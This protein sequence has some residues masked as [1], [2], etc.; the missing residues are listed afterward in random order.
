MATKKKVKS[1][2]K[3]KTPM[4]TRRRRKRASRKTPFSRPR[5][6][7]AAPRRRRR[8]KR[9]FLSAGGNSGLMANVKHNFQ[10]ALG[11]AAF[12]A[13]RLIQMPLWMRLLLGAG[14]SMGLS[15]AGL[16]FIG[17][18]LMGATTYHAGQTLL[19][20]TLLNDDGEDL[21]DADFVDADTLEDS[22]YTDEQGNAIVMDDD[23]IMYTLND[24]GDLEAIGDAYS[25]NEDSDMQTVS[26]IPMQ[27][28]YSLNS[29]YSLASGY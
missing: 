17:A 1:K 27:D 21:E 4:I 25:L 29:P 5:T 13:T 10:G 7:S 19:P 8:R 14:G 22:G 26:M 11:G 2:I 15:M 3:R 24:D 23:G 16:P 20:A 18:G 28:Q 9:G 6:L 12:T